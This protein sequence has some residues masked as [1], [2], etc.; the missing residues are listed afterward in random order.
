MNGLI[1]R[2]ERAPR[3]SSSVPDR[4][5]TFARGARF[6]GG[7]LAWTRRQ[8]PMED[9]FVPATTFL[10]HR[11][12]RRRTHAAATTTTAS[13][14][15]ALL[16]A[17][18]SQSTHMWCPV[19]FNGR[20]WGRT[21]GLGEPS[22]TDRV[23]TRC[24]R[25]PRRRARRK[26]TPKRSEQVAGGIRLA[27]QRNRRLQGPPFAS[28]G[29]RKNKRQP[30]RDKMTGRPPPPEVYAHESESPWPVCAAGKKCAFFT[31]FKG[32]EPASE[33]KIRGTT[34]GPTASDSEVGGRYLP[35]RKKKKRHTRTA[36]PSRRVRL[37]VYY[38]L[39]F[40]VHEKSTARRSLSRIE[41]NRPRQ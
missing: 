20:A 14:P 8:C 33:R 3:R 34:R 23:E 15:G 9:L 4:P 17:C 37:L 31:I 1:P 19:R 36:S 7:W 11:S 40:Q 5:Y 22:S 18:P 25:P 39:L 32:P 24:L 2:A 29:P 41:T 26:D 21:H 27:S 28:R 38:W 13:P 35:P 16:V 12:R 6:A 30:A 10:R